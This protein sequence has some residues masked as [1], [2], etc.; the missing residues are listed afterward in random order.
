[1]QR[2]TVT[3][4]GGRG[5][6]RSVVVEADNLRIEGGALVFTL[7]HGALVVAYGSGAWD[8][9]VEGGPGEAPDGAQVFE[10]SR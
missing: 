6:A 4:P 8:T 5:A 9:V 7:D 1:M 10:R 3:L 2:W